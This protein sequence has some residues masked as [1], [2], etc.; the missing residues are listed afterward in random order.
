MSCD[1]QNKNKNAIITRNEKFKK[2][3]SSL[4]EYILMYH[5]ILII[6]NQRSRLVFKSKVNFVI[7][8]DIF[9]TV[10]GRVGNDENDG[11]GNDGT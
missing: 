2:K 6:L 5:D 1:Q 3:N 7:F 10:D 9:Q 8:S 4:L 11:T